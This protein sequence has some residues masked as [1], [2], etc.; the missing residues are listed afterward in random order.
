MK[1]DQDFIMYDKKDQNMVYS[2]RLTRHMSHHKNQMVLKD[3]SKF[4]WK[5]V[6]EEEK[7]YGILSGITYSGISVCKNVVL[8]YFQENFDYH[9]E[10]NDFLISL[11]NSEISV[12]KVSFQ[13]LP[14]NVFIKKFES[15]KCFLE[16]IIMLLKHSS[17][18]FNINKQTFRFGKLSQIIS[19]KSIISARVKSMENCFIGPKS[20]VAEF[21]QIDNSILI[22]NCKIHKSARIM[23][24]YLAQ[25]TTVNANVSLYNCMIMASNVTISKEYLEEKGI[26]F[27]IKDDIISVR[28]V[29][30]LKNGNI[31]CNQKKENFNYNDDE[32]YNLESE[33]EEEDSGDYFEREV[34]D[35]LSTLSEDF[36]NLDQIQTDVVSLRLSQNRS[37]KDC[38]HE[39]L[40][41]I[42]GY[43]FNVKD[44]RFGIFELSLKREPLSKAEFMKKLTVLNNFTSILDKF[45]VSADEEKYILD[46]LKRTSMEYPDILIFTLT[47]MFFKMKIIKSETLIEWYNFL[48]NQEE[49]S[50]FDSKLVEELKAFIDYLERLNE[51]TESETESESEDEDDED[52]EDDDED[53]EEDDDDSNKSEN[54]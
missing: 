17:F 31:S 44:N 3:H 8:N 43:L 26:S 41:F 53:D 16:T 36:D 11:L 19:N 49:I 23:Y 32:S 46:F 24:S 51:E 47:Q 34:K 54:A 30:I 28:D 37:F 40:V 4:K 38:L 9:C 27:E 2:E 35:V 14:S 48:K 7:E 25:G 1:E 12:D 10:Q 42:W 15:W 29:V 5:W 45:T 22:E 20:E 39:I 13:V 33:S 6:F 18:K 21:S 52:D 50:E